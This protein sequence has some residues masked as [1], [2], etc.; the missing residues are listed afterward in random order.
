MYTSRALGIGFESK[1]F[2]VLV[3]E[4]EITISV[5]FKV[6]EIFITACYH[7]LEFFFDTYLMNREQ[8]THGDQLRSTMT[9]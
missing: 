2:I 5:T 1:T 4:R 7:P 6:F 8:C 9:N 3:I